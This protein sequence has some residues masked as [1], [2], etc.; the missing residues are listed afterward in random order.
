MIEAVI[1]GERGLA[2]ILSLPWAKMPGDLDLSRRH[3]IGELG[4]KRRG[5]PKTHRVHHE[6][7]NQKDMRIFVGL[8]RK[9]VQFRIFGNEGIDQQG[10]V[11][12]SLRLG[13]VRSARRALVFGRNMNDQARQMNL[14]DV[15]R[16]SKKTRPVER[17]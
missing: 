8:P 16:L 17:R 4:L 13:R 6:M 12:L 2:R 14:L 15:E 11:R 10:N 3:S 1:G 7:V 5:M 9:Q